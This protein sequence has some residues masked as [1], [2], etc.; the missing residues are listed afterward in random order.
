MNTRAN[1][2]W[3]LELQQVDKGDQAM[4]LGVMMML[5]MAM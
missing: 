4:S 2:Q 3:N 1:P 5:M